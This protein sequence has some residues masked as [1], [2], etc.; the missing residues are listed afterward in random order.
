[1]NRVTFVVYQWMSVVDFEKSLAMQ[2]DHVLDS[3]GVIEIWMIDVWE[4]RN[5]SFLSLLQDG[6]DIPLHRFYNASSTLRLNHCL[7]IDSS[8]MN[9]LSVKFI[10]DLFGRNNEEIF[11]LHLFSVF[12]ICLQFYECPS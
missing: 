4:H 1:M 2:I 7:Q 12:G 5:S 10:S 3:D 8:E 9:R 6:I 11:V